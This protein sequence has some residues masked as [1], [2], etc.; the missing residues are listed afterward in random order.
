MKVSEIKYHRVTIE[1]VREKSKAIIDRVKDAASVEDVL[2]ARDDYNSLFTDLFTEY[3]L[4]HM[5]YTIN[6]ADEFYIKERDYY[7]EIIPEVQNIMLEYSNALLDSK[8]RSELEKELS[9]L[10]FK[11]YEIEKKSMSPEIIEEMVEENKVVSE[12]SQLM[13][14]LTFEFRGETMPKTL[15]TKYFQDGDRNTRKEAYEALGRG[16]DK[17]SD[18]LD[19]IFDRLVK[20]RDKMARKMGYKNFVELGYYRMGRLCYDEEMIKKFRQ[21]VLKDIVPVVAR[22]KT[23]NAK[24]MGIDKF[25]LYDNDIII[26]GGNPKPIVDTEGIF[27]AAKEMYHEMSE[28]TGKFID[29]MLE[30]EAFDV[31]SRENKWG[32]GYCT[33]FDKYKQPFILANFNGTSADIDVMTHEAGHAFADYMT[34]NNRFVHELGIGGM[35]TAETHSMS[36]EFFAWKYIDK[37]FGDKTNKYKFMHAFDA[38]SF[39]PYGTIVDYFQH[40]VYENPEMTPADR[41]EA[42]NKLEAEFRPY[43]STE[44]IPYLEKGTRWQYQM[45]IF[46]TPFYYIDYC[47]AQTA[48][49]GFLME[50]QKDYD[51]AFARYVRFLS[52]GGEKLFTDLLEEAGLNSPFKDGSLKILSSEVENL[53]NKI[54]ENL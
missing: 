10:I 25:M 20:I 21:N 39:I 43:L 51:D 47:L 4:A 15:L 24:A 44:G 12:Y 35:E 46:E 33:S 5:R 18:Q 49:F 42:W 13:A 28:D 38:L 50:S 2:K 3:S 9:P 48:A 17:V 54:K 19:D 36:M 34:S 7:D 52:Q 40:I 8:F 26:P 22:L 23:E 32:G 30:N 45:H 6:T 41:N 31:L 1:E 37:F 29:M 53:L 11:K 16:L 14:G 27:N